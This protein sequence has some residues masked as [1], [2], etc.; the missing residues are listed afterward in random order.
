MLGSVIMI[1]LL[2]FDPFLQ[3]VVSYP[4]RWVPA[5]EKATIVRAQK[6][7]ARNEDGLP[8]PSI[9]DLTMKSAIY[10][11]IFDNQNNAELGIAHTCSSGNC[12]WPKFSSLAVCN[13]CVDIRHYVKRSCDKHG[14]HEHSLPDGPSLHGFDRQIN[15]SVTNIS[16]S[17]SD[18]YPSVVRFSSL[19]VKNVNGSDELLALECSLWYCIQTYQAS[20]DGGKPF[21]NVLSSWRNDSAHLSQSHDFIF[22]PPSSIIDD[23]TDPSVYRVVH[24]AATA[25]NSFISEM[26]TG[27]GRL[28]DRGSAFS[29]DT[30]QA[31]YNSRNL[32]TQISNLAVSMT[33]NIREQNSSHSSPVLGTTWETET[34]VHVRWRWLS[35]PLVVLF[36]SLLF[37]LGSII[38]T[39]QS[40]VMIWK[41]NNLAILSHGRDIKLKHSHQDFRVDKLSRLGEQANSIMVE[42]AL[43]PDQNWKLVER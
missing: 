4:S 17:L 39:T 20:V 31:I 15:S 2:L 35:F 9:V 29:S 37:L 16:S 7:E 26:F 43:T 12:T 1:L 38:E 11:G 33:N 3:Q 5:G 41:T 21:Q 30:I 10:N 8:L 6:Y 42:L 19:I 13:K 24:L 36:L 28:D 22:H 23:I 32:T 34:Y 14:C 27:H 18:I 25:L 40:K